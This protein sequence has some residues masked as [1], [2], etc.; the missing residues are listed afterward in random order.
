M[1]LLNILMKRASDF[2]RAL[3]VKDIGILK[4][5]ISWIDDLLATGIQREERTGRWLR[6]QCRWLTWRMKLCQEHVQC[7]W[8]V[9][10]RWTAYDAPTLQCR[11]VKA[12]RLAYAV[13]FCSNTYSLIMLFHSLDNIIL[14]NKRVHYTVSA[15]ATV[16]VTPHVKQRMTSARDL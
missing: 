9:G 13:F 6:R 8:L 12:H 5:R 16:T 3:E 2:V 11:A 10:H 7:R 1:S 14:V 4:R 15:F